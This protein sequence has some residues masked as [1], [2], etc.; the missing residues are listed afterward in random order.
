M[1]KALFDRIV[2]QLLPQ[3]DDPAA[4]QALV[5][6]ALY[7]APVLP[8]IDWTGAAEPFTR[9]LV[10]QL[11]K[12]SDI[13]ADRPAVVAL[14]DEVKAQVGV[15]RQQ[16]IDTLILELTTDVERQLAELRQVI[17]ADQAAL[18]AAPAA[19]RAEV[20]TR[21]AGAQAK[22]AE[23]EKVQTGALPAAFAGVLNAIRRE[24]DPPF[25]PPETVE[26]LLR[27]SPANATQQR[28]AQI[29]EWSLPRY[30]LD[31]RFVNL[32]LLLDQGEATPQRWQA[33][34]LRFDDLRQVL[35]KVPDP[36][37]VLLGAPG[38]GKSTLLR[39]L[40]LDHSIDQLR[41]AGPAVTFFIQL[42]SYRDTTEPRDW[43]NA[44]WAKRY[45][46]LA[47][48]D[49]YL[50]QGRVMLLLDALN[51][52][53]HSSDA[54]YDHKVGLWRAFIQEI[55]TPG[56][57]AV[58][59]CR[60]LDYS[61]SLS[62]PE[63]RVPQIE[64]QPM[65]P[66]QVRQFIERY[67]PARAEA[68]WQELAGSPPF[69][70]YRTPIYLK[71]LLDQVEQDQRLP[72]GKAE[73]FTQFIR[74][75]IR[76]NIDHPLLGPPATDLLD[77]RDRT[78]LARD[79]WPSPFDLP[80]RG[81]LLPSL[82]RLAFN[83]QQTG[84]ETEGATV[85]IDYDEACRQLDCA[86]AEA[87]LTAGVA[88][89]VLDEDIARDELTFFHQL[90]QEYFAARQL[91]R[92]P[93]PNLV[94]RDWAVWTVTPTLAETLADLADGDPLPPLPQ[95]GWEET[96]LTAAP[97]APD[98]IAFIRD[99]IPHNLPLAARCAASPEVGL[100]SPQPSPRGIQG[101]PGPQA[102]E[103]GEHSTPSQPPPARGRSQ[104]FPPSGGDRGGENMGQPKLSALDGLKHDLQTALI[105]RTQDMTAD[106]RA[107]I[108][109]GL[110]LGEL[111]DPRL[112]R[113]TG[114]HGDYLRPPLV[115]I[116][117]GVYPIGDDD[118]PY[119]FEKPAHTVELAAFQIGQFPVTNAEYALFMAA[120]G[121]EDEQWWETA[122]A[123]AWRRGEGSTEGSKQQ[124]RDNRKT[125]QSVTEDDIRGLVSQNR[126]TSQQADDWITIRNWSDER[127]EQQLEETF[128]A[129]KIYREPAYWQD[130]RFNNPAQPVVGVTWFEARAYCRW[131]SAQTGETFDLPSEVQFEAAARGL[132]G[133]A[134]PYGDAFEVSRSNTFESHLRR[135]TPV[136]IFDNA[137]PEG[138]FDL[139]GNAYTW[140]T[141]IYNQEQFPYPYRADDSREDIRSIARRVVRGGSWFNVHGFARAS[142]R[143][144][145]LPD[146]R[147]GSFGFRVCRP[148]S[149]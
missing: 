53:P 6:S 140:T 13:A 107:R 126:I 32:T 105:A 120:G 101:R 104:Y 108:A 93:D 20:K 18:A 45:P 144:N 137:T 65:A 80:E 35:A 112:A 85:R 128:P 94:H 71:L 119:D 77:R 4:R 56:N 136:G 90:L 95:T 97:M 22:L 70:L 43:L 92:T 9:R 111:G 145:G 16:Q 39:R 127:F 99:L 132:M 149:Q 19:E 130:S 33:D 91:A 116:P 66:E 143:F 5:T 147:D 63:L 62:R 102:F 60:S 106:L 49:D 131:L 141:T 17:Q 118:S 88:L 142:F 69:D 72:R 125:F 121:Y 15:D 109:A 40:Q 21:L 110:A 23:L 30:A 50:G 117:A 134:Y 103:A 146:F 135:T 52:M 47:P 78:K 10:G 139:S 31:K 7:G 24:T 54:E 79:K 36:A 26:A 59:A 42:N 29:A 1:D 115:E 100:P 133:R 84:L 28:L 148:P 8:H 86:Q 12:Y 41:Q 38:S 87:I 25:L 46:A 2:Q 138:A 64:V 98:P 37:L 74:Q 113:H 114:P 73:L 55:V 44:A 96:T 122:E 3:M 124:W 51:E 68:I 76:R 27:H 89:A 123:Q 14:L 81:L 48:L 57:R 11:D 67:S 129:G 61:A 83:M 34:D 75:Q 82:S 58:F